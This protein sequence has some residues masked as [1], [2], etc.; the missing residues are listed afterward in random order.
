M[1]VHKVNLQLKPLHS[2]LL[3]GKQKNNLMKKF[4]YFVVLMSLLPLSGWCYEGD[5]FNAETEEGIEL[6]FTVTNEDEKTCTVNGLSEPWLWENDF[7]NLTIPSEA[8]GYTV[9]AIGYGAFGGMTINKI[10]IPA[11]IKS[12]GEGAFFCR[13]EEFVSL[14][15]Y[16]FD[17]EYDV[18]AGEYDENDNFKIEAT[19]RVPRGAYERYRAAKGWNNFQT[20]IELLNDGDVFT[21]FTVE[22]VGMTFRVISEEENTCEVY[23]D[24]GHAIP[25][26][27]EGV[28]TIPAIAC[29]YKVVAI[30]NDAISYEDW[31]QPMVTQINLPETVTHLGANFCRYCKSLTKVYIPKSVTRIPD[32]SFYACT[33]I[34]TIEVDE[35]NPVYDSREN[36]NSIIETNKNYLFVGCKN[37]F[38]PSSVTELGW[39][40]FQEIHIEQVAIPEGVTLVPVHC[41]AYSGLKTVSLPESLNGI[42]ERAFAGTQLESIHIPKNVSY[43]WYNAFQ[44]CSQLESISVAEDN[45]VYDSREN[46]NAIISTEDDFLKLGC[47]NTIIPEGVK[48][49]GPDAFYYYIDEPWH[50]TIPKS[51]N[52]IYADAFTIYWKLESITCLIEEPFTIAESA[53]N[54]DIYKKTTLYVP[55][56]TKAK[57][58][59]TDGWKLFNRIVEL[60]ADGNIPTE[61]DEMPA[62]TNA[63]AKECYNMNGQRIGSEH[64]GLNIVRMSDGSVKKVLNQ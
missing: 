6:T 43:I 47:K 35:A 63:T 28:V 22:G 51:V 42:E 57:Y 9:T 21:A 53:F 45:P 23:S 16:P 25:I 37:S 17:L 40:T 60:D 12:I 46:C 44:H 19:L 59:T 4:I 7:T 64:Q 36:C 32:L 58:E 30:G 38:I 26:E 31:E 14:I 50:L 39:A 54:E 5:M 48:S 56:G 18:F 62:E 2:G 41:F 27:T 52:E 13:F 24:Y 20:S 8:N 34:E 33:H 15:E 61:I 29:G 49:I 3:R 55:K 10:T 11:T 1:S